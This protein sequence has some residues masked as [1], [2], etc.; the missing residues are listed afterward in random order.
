MVARLDELNAALRAEDRRA[1]AAADAA[2]ALKQSAFPPSRVTPTGS[3][4]GM[5]SPYP[6]PD[7]SRR[8]L[9]RAAN[10]VRSGSGKVGLEEREKELIRMKIE[11]LD[12]AKATVDREH[13]LHGGGGAAGGSGGG[14][15]R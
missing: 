3:K 6:S 11:R 15:A 13:I 8:D 2:A 10:S 1:E 12:A 5:V 7:G 9:G 4:E 14:G